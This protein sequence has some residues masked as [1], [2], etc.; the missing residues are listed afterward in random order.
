M[1]AASLP[2]GGQ[3][4][5]ACHTRVWRMQRRAHQCGSCPCQAARTCSLS[6]A[7]LQALRESLMSLKDVNAALQIEL[8]TKCLQALARKQTNTQ[9]S[10]WQG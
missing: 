5:F 9:K 8:S 10:S 7:W 2:L 1:P 4:A 3:K 6:W